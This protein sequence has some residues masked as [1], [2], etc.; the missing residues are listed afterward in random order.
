MIDEEHQIAAAAAV[1]RIVHTYEY[2]V[3]V[4]KKVPAPINPNV[5][6]SEQLANGTTAQY[7]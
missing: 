7:S 3:R 4:M 1:L 5:K 6:S 2:E